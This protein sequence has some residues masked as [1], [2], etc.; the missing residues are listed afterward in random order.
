MQQIYEINSLRPEENSVSYFR[1]IDFAKMQSRSLQI[2]HLKIELT[3]FTLF[4]M[5]LQSSLRL[6]VSVSLR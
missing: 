6:S 5:V 3:L 4:Y 2:S 1:G